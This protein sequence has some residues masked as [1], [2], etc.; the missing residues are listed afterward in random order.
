[1][2]F[3]SVSPV[4]GSV[5]ATG[6]TITVTWD[7]AVYPTITYRGSTGPTETVTSYS[8]VTIV[9]GAGF[10]GE[11]ADQGGGVW[12]TTFRRDA[13]WA[14]SPFT[15]A[16]QDTVLSSETQVNYTLL[17]EGQYP[18]DMQ[19]FN[20][21]VRGGPSGSASDLDSVIN[22]STPDNDVVIPAGNP[23]IFTELEATGTPLTVKR[24]DANNTDPTLLVSDTSG[25]NLRTGLRVEL[26]GNKQT[27]I[28]PEGITFRTHT[29]GAGGGVEYTIAGE[30]VSTDKGFQDTPGADITVSGG[31]S[32][33]N[34]DG[35]NLKL[36]A[37]GV[38]S[39]S[40]GVPGFVQIGYR[41]S[42]NQGLPRLEH[43]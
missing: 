40:T 4:S 19:P 35:G 8:G 39:P 2:A 6:D 18:P 14:N 12:T 22:Y 16:I 34:Q 23:I 13:G 28:A 27:D 17:A 33:G 7:T 1:M 20:D 42:E 36:D 43:L 11:F 30:L 15:L 31:W 29:E 41:S 38:E 32:H 26:S 9:F 25:N 37:G 24:S 10:T 5:V 3:V 21:P